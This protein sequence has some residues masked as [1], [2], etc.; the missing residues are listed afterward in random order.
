MLPVLLRIGIG[1]GET[2]I[3]EDPIRTGDPWNDAVEY[4]PLRLVFVESQIDVVTQIS[5][6]LGAAR[7]IGTRDVRVYGVGVASVVAGLV[8]QERR[9]I[10]RGSKAKPHDDRILGLVNQ[11]ID[12]A[13][14][15][16]V[17]VAKVD[18]IGNEAR[19]TCG[20]G[21]KRPMARRN[22]GL[23]TVFRIAGGEGRMRRVRVRRFVGKEPSCTFE[24]GREAAGDPIRVL[25]PHRTDD[26]SAICLV[27][28][29]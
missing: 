13:V 8:S 4:L 14:V 27:R 26:W 6:R 11:L 15:E 1:I 19:L 9:D 17:K 20:T 22:E 24:I 21:P 2:N 7:G 18:G 3:D 10:P 28:D 16:P 25:V 23:R 29:G 5:A 12:L